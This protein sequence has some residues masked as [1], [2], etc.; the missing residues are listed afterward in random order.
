MV[1]KCLPN[2]LD[3]LKT[4]LDSEEAKPEIIVICEA[5]PKSKG[6]NSYYQRCQYRDIIPTK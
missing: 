3:E 5:K 1:H 2:K 6:T 4:R